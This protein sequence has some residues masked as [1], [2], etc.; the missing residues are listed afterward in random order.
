MKTST[1]KNFFTSPLLVRHSI[2]L[3]VNCPEPYLIHVDRFRLSCV[4]SDESLVAKFVE[5]DYEGSLM[6]GDVINLF[7]RDNIDSIIDGL[8]ERLRDWV[9][10]E[11]RDC[12]GPE[13]GPAEDYCIFEVVTVARDHVEE[14]QRDKER[15]EAYLR[16]VTI[17]A[18]HGWL[19]C[20]P[21]LSRPESFPF[22]LAN[23]LMAKIMQEIQTLDA[24]DRSS[25]RDNVALIGRSVVGGT[26]WQASTMTWRRPS[27][28]RSK[29]GSLGSQDHALAWEGLE[30]TLR[31][32]DGLLTMT[33]AER[34][35][36]RRP[37]QDDE[38]N[39]WR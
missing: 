14:Y 4:D 29:V 28:A 20:H 34:L 26:P 1:K 32:V 18:I 24:R 36:L 25:S 19:L 15:R 10:W 33:E 21:M 39:R 13:H 8:P 31:E 11:L 27:G 23:D 35:L 12:Y 6:I 5:M 17:P 30:R 3:T 2:I 37:L 7:T 38:R 22:E 16:Q 9:V